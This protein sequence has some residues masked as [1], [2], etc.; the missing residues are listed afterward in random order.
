MVS[1]AQKIVVGI[2]IG[3]QLTRIIIAEE[4]GKLNTQPKILGIGYS[5]TF[6]VRNGYIISPR[7]VVS[8][9]NEARH[10][11]EKTSNVEI[12][13]AYVSLGGIG[14]SSEIGGGAVSAS[15]PDGEIT[16]EDITNVT[17]VAKQVFFQQKKNIKI[18]HT[19]PLK[20]RLDGIEILGNPIG[21]KG[22]RLEVKMVFV[23]AHEQHFNDMV[24]VIT[25]SGIDIIEII[26]SPIAESLITLNRRQKMVGCGLLNIGAETTSLIVFDNELPVSVAVFPLGSSH[27]TNDIALGLQISLEEAEEIKMK[28]ITHTKYSKKKYEEI[29]HARMQEILEYAQSHLRSIKR[30]GLLPAGIILSGGGSLLNGFEEMIKEILK[31]PAVTTQAH[32]VMNTKRDLDP[33]WLTAYGLCFL[34]DDDALY[35]TTFIKNALKETKRGI[36]KIL[37]EFLP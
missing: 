27:I 11:A 5:E 16:E 17:S 25:H 13:R 26:A 31:L 18:I 21:M 30:D 22:S 28:G 20:Y 19:I 4:T 32:E 36:L 15:R 37:K 23:T 9:I 29:I 6:G 33:S 24:Q 2:D 34:E 12:R 14:L 10:M 1:H 3:S 7:D 35:G 8:S